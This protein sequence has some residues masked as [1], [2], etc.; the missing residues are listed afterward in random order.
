MQG[1]VA[2]SMPPDKHLI[3]VLQQQVADIGGLSTAGHKVLEGA[4][5]V[6]PAHLPA[7]RWQMPVGRVPVRADH[8]R[9]VGAEQLFDHLPAAAPANGEDR[10]ARRHR[11]PQ[12]GPGAALPPARLVHIDPGLLANVGAGLHRRGQRRRHLLLQRADRAHRQLDAKGVGQQG[13]DV[14][15]AQAIRAGQQADPGLHAGPEGAPRHPRGP[16]GF[17]QQVAGRT[18]QGVQLILDDLGSHRRDHDLLVTPR[19]GV[20]AREPLP[21]SMAGAGL[22]RDPLIHAPGRHQRPA[23]AFVSRL[24]ARRASRGSTPAGADAGVRGGR[25]LG[26]APASALAAGQ[27]LLQGRHPGGLLLHDLLQMGHPLPQADHRLLHRRRRALPVAVGNRN[28]RRLLHGLAQVQRTRGPQL[29]PRYPQRPNQNS[30]F[31]TCGLNRR[32][33][34]GY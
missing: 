29:I 7:R 23:M 5:Q 12:P 1:A 32:G 21:A 22:D 17:G 2:H 14:A 25:G 26:A 15:L 11:R 6:R 9:A 24:P 20:L 8:G 19:M 10:N 18:T 3:G 13:H 30:D 4:P 27:F 31:S 33:L 28:L 34:N 16:V